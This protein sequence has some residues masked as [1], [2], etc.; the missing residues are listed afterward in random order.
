MDMGCSSDSYIAALQRQPQAILRVDCGP[1]GG[2]NVLRSWSRGGKSERKAAQEHGQGNGG[3]DCG[4][5]ISEAAPRPPS[6]GHEGVVRRVLVRVQAALPHLWVIPLPLG[7]FGILVRVSEAVRIEGI[8]VGPVPC[9]P[10]NIVHR[11]ENVSGSFEGGIE[12]D[13]GPFGQLYIIEAA[14]D[15]QRGLRVHPQR[16][17]NGQTAKLQVF[18]VLHRW[19]PVSQYPIHFLLQLRQKIWQLCKLID[20]PSK[21]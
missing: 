19:K 14:P 5:R 8:G 7:D 16:F 17:C 9:V 10:L 12:R 21:S 6:E 15:Q 13:G 4:K 2:P 3:L 18:H 20:G 11:N 1:S